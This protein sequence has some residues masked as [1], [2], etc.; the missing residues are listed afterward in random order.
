MFEAA[1]LAR[2]RLAPLLAAFFIGR[3]VSY[4][5]YV[6]TASIAHDRLSQLFSRGLFSPQAIATQLIGVALVVAVV[7]IDWP[8]VIDTIRGR[9]SARRGHPTSP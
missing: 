5:F 2:I 9:W 8:A 7:L 4:S 6:G 3:L 1:G